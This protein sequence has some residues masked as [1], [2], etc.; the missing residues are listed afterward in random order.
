MKRIICA[1]LALCV[2]ACEK[3]EGFKWAEPAVLQG[4]VVA[5]A[6][7]DLTPDQFADAFN[8][9]A[10]SL[11]RPFRVNKGEIMYDANHDYFEQ[12][13][14]DSAS[15]TV[16]LSR[17]TGRITGVTVLIAEKNGTVDMYAVKML[18]QIIMMATDPELSKKKSADVVTDMLKESADNKNPHIFPQR[19]FNHVRYALRNRSGIGYW[20]VATPS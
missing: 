4:S 14:S 9:A 15:L 10:K 3:N 8:V 20:L 7:F 17:V 12:Q 5:G 13:L 1:L 18:A 2:V 16:S 6:Q 19:F 11:D